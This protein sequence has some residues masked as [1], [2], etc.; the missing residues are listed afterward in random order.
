MHPRP[1]KYPNP[2]DSEREESY[3]TPNTRVKALERD[4]R[5]KISNILCPTHPTPPL[6]QRNNLKKTQ[7]KS[8][9][10]PS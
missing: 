5:G 7:K 9:V 6:P 1:L 3:Y 10:S 2:S 4:I 8:K